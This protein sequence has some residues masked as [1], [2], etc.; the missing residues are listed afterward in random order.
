MYTFRV[1]KEMG[2]NINIS[3]NSKFLPKI[4]TELSMDI[5]SC[6]PKDYQVIIATENNSLVLTF[7]IPSMCL[8]NV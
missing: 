1:R 3:M 7:G 5:L 8:I 2:R 6:L 4:L